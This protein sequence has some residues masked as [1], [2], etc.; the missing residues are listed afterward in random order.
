MYHQYPSMG[1]PVKAV[2]KRYFDLTDREPSVQP[3]C[4][5]GGSSRILEISYGSIG[6]QASPEII[7][8]HRK[9]DEQIGGKKWKHH[10]FFQMQQ[11]HLILV[12]HG[13]TKSAPVHWLRYTRPNA[14]PLP[15][16]S[17]ARLNRWRWGPTDELVSCF[18]TSLDG[19]PLK[20]I[21]QRLTNCQL[22]SP[23]FSTFLCMCGSQWAVWNII[24]YQI[25]GKFV[26]RRVQSLFL[27]LFPAVH[28]S[29]AGLNYIELAFA[30]I[31]PRLGLE[32]TSR[33]NMKKWW[34]NKRM[35]MDSNKKTELCKIP[36]ASTSW[37]S[38]K[39]NSWDVEHGDRTVGRYVTSASVWTL[40]KW[41]LWSEYLGVHELCGYFFGRQ[42]I[43]WKV[44]VTKY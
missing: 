14:Q 35:W 36:T 24:R 1:C 34:L 16:S 9:Y 18:H 39:V 26:G 15:R 33:K 21:S 27:D 30:T 20:M 13:S 17:A 5:N 2:S 32:S 29:A 4:I 44:K 41:W 28:R 19:H 22:P 25:N 7:Q 38:S 6:Y 3:V 31:V 11:T 10:C 8:F 37:I 12:A 40:A 23:W 43:T 42:N